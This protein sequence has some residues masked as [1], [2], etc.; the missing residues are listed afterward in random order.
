MT[1]ALFDPKIK[2]EVLIFVLFEIPFS[3]YKGDIHVKK[4]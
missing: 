2:S 4:E 1:N 3:F